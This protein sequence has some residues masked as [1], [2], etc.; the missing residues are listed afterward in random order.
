[1]FSVEDYLSVSR[2]LAGSLFC[3]EVL[4]LK[5]PGVGRSGSKII[6]C[7]RS[8]FGTCSSRVGGLLTSTDGSN[9][10]FG[11]APSFVV[12]SGGE[13]VVFLVRYGSSVSGRRSLRGLRRCGSVRLSTGSVYGCTLSKVLR[14]D[15]CFAGCCSMMTITVD[16]ALM[17]GSEVADVLVRG[18]GS[19][20]DL[21][22][23]R[24]DGVRMNFGAVRSCCCCVGS[25]GNVF[26]LRESEVAGRLGQCTGRYGGCLQMYRMRT[27]SETNFLSTV[28][29][30]LAGPGSGVLLSAVSDVRLNGSHVT[31]YKVRFIVGSLRSV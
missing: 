1:M 25:G 31:S 14:C 3:S 6:M 9:G 22:L 19:G 26:G 18:N 27:V 20:G 11:K 28:M 29:L 12:G 4:S 24:S 15:A 10:K 17:S 23:L 16:K 5:C 30:T 2:R 13:D 7:G 8:S 21:G